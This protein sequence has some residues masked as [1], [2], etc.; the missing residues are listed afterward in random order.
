MMRI[1]LIVL[2]VVLIV[3]VL[4]FALRQFEGRSN[5]ETDLNIDLNE[6]KPEAW[7]TYGDG[8]QRVNLDDDD[9]EE[10]L[11]LYRYDGAP[12]GG[13]IYDGQTAPYGDLS[14]PVPNQT[15][16]Y[17]VPYRLLPD[18][19]AGKTNG[20]LGD[21]NVDFKQIFLSLDLAGEEPPTTPR[22]RLLVRG[23]RQDGRINRYSVFQ[24][25]SLETGYAGALA[26]TPGWFSLSEENPDD[27]AEAENWVADGS[28]PT[29][30]WAWEPQSDRSNICRRTPWVLQAS[31]DDQNPD[32]FRA[33]Y[34]INDLNFC[35][36]DIPAEPAF[37]EGQMLAYL[38]DGNAGRLDESDME[39]PEFTGAAV[40]RVTA[41]EVLDENV[42][43]PL[44][45]AG[46]VDF[47]FEGVP[48]RMYWT[49]TMIPPEDIKDINKWRITS[50]IER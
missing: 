8:L 48:Y 36:G 39:I 29:K 4:A 21:A 43:D 31:G 11:L 9:E 38:L 40:S 30:I 26:F 25:I 16:S 10:W 27:W 42:G 24:W 37:P 7:T 17:L 28:F 35:N 44:Q 14:I 45:V 6:I 46:E 47:Q 12:L 50:L 34:A 1:I 49:A 33:N 3:A 18:Y 23:K 22:D 32:L 2:G 13:V 19:A 41:P 20:Y 15:P 5:T